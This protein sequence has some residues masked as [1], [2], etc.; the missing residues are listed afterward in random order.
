MIAAVAAVSC[1]ACC[2]DE[3]VFYHR[4]H[5]FL[6]S[7]STRRFV[8]GCLLDA[9]AEG[10]FAYATTS[11]SVT[12]KG[13]PNR[14]S[15]YIGHGDHCLFFVLFVAYVVCCGMFVFWNFVMNAF[16]SSLYDIYD[17]SDLRC[18][19]ISTSWGLLLFGM[20]FQPEY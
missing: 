17:I 6:F 1:E 3:K 19:R 16:F 12:G 10:I 18:S 20:S 5:T 8:F 2:C 11:T 14:T 15:H 13:G 4:P 9:S 7:G